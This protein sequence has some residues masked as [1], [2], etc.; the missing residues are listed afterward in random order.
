VPEKNP[1][2]A[3]A[4]AADAKEAAPAAAAPA[5]KKKLW[6]I[7]GALLG[8]SAIGGAVAT[9]AIPRARPVVAPVAEA[10]DTVG[11]FEISDL[12][13]NLARSGGLHFCMVELLVQYK[14]RNPGGVET[15]LGLRTNPGATVPMLTGPISTAARDRLILLL[16]SKGIE[17]LE[18]REKKE[19]LKKEIQ[20]ELAPL[21]FPE[22]DGEVGE[23][24]F[25][26]FL[27]Q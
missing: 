9:L 13:S 27:L 3:A 19:L 4:P 17:D 7:L 6:I 22:K 26:D 5:S 18:G 2:P 21:V 16:A 12:K 1:Q 20:A 10:R 8:V 25:G 14:T 15:R 23:V 11:W 24:L